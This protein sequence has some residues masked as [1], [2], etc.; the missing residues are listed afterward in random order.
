METKGTFVWFSSSDGN[1]GLSLL[2]TG[3]CEENGIDATNNVSYSERLSDHHKHT[4]DDRTIASVY[5]P[6]VALN[7]VE[8]M[9][10]KEL[11]ISQ[12]LIF[13]ARDV[14]S[15]EQLKHYTN[16]PVWTQEK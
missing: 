6:E 2:T 4:Y 10:L 3:Q 11:A 15:N 1:T 13:R 14:S 16:H 8:I 5:L 12:G 9:L 7:S